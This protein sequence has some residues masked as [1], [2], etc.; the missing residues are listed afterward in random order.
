MNLSTKNKP[1]AL[2]F[3][4][5]QRWNIVHCTLG[6]ISIHYCCSR[7]FFSSCQSLKGAQILLWHILQVMMNS[8]MTNQQEVSPLRI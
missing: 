2:F 1:L 8:Q 6:L 4:T 7:Y 3:S 5:E